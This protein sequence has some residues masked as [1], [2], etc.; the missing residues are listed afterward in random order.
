[1]VVLLAVGVSTFLLG[2][3]LM[4]FGGD[5]FGRTSAGHDTHSRSLVG[6]RALK[7]L[8]DEVGLPVVTVRRAGRW[9]AKP[10]APLLLIEPY[11][12]DGSGA[13]ESPLLPPRD[14]V[15][16]P[17]DDQLR[18]AMWALE[19][20]ATLIVVLPKWKVAAATTHRAWI[21]SKNLRARSEV[22]ALLARL[23]ADPGAEAGESAVVRPDTT[24]AWKAPGLGIDE[25]VLDLGAHPQLLAPDAGFQP[26]V[27]CA[28]GVL[29]GERGVPGTEGCLVVVADPDLLA[30]QG[31]A[32]GDH[33][34]LVLALLRDWARAERVLV[35]ESTHGFTAHRSVLKLAFTY[36][37]VVLVVHGV[38]ALLL[39][40]WMVAPRFGR[41][42]VPPPAL[43]PGKRLLIDNSAALLEAAGDPGEGLRGYLRGA[44]R[45]AARDLAVTPGGRE[46]DLPAQLERLGR[47]RGVAIDLVAI[48][49]AA[50]QEQIKPA[51]ALRL[52]AQMH[53]WRER[54]RAGPAGTAR[55]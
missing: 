6:H 35:D 5:L 33:A 9:R 47:T 15:E 39:V 30:N 31:I 26:L 54:L 44:M 46:D 52:A 12:V 19:P 17:R 14:D 4:A 48:W 7:E 20:E 32:H 43:P 24:T 10:D 18:D 55:S 16:R 38:L 3:L 27:A 50:Q 1:M 45:S 36:P 49:S 28:E 2:L 40:V 13:G 22:E 41:A 37:R 25:P 8:L 23:A 42:L 29:V 21:S 51:E 53:A 34:A 11:A